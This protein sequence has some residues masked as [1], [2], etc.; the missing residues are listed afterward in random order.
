MTIEK[1]FPPLDIVVRVGDLHVGRFSNSM[2]HFQTTIELYRRLLIPL[3][4]ELF[5]NNPGRNITVLFYG[6]QYDNKQQIS[7]VINDMFIDLNVELSKYAY[8]YYL[9]GN[10]DT[11]MV[12]NVS[13]NANKSFSLVEK[14]DVINTPT[15]IKDI[16]GN[17][18]MLSP[19]IHELKNME[20]LIKISKE[21]NVKELHGHNS[22]Y[23]FQQEGIA[24]EKKNNLGISD[25][26]HFDEVIMGHIHT[27]QKI[28][29]VRYLG[30][31][32][33][34]RWQEAG[35][36]NVIE[37]KDYSSGE[38]RVV[39][40]TFSPK[41]QKFNYL[42]IIEKTVP[43]INELLENNYNEF[44]IPATSKQFNTAF[45]TEHFQ[46][47]KLL[48]FTPMGEVITESFDTNSI[49]I[50]SIEEY[51]GKFIDDLS[52]IML[53]KNPYVI[54]D[55]NRDF[56]KNRFVNDYKEQLQQTKENIN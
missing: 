35:N 55:E 14:M 8:C 41:Y 36:K 49:E 21:A 56:F 23:G 43:E 12:S 26:G 28:K 5:D 53:E 31:P 25:F 38:L 27:M 6:D 34:T 20:K 16:N 17:S 45:F 50:L 19:W 40:N 32:Y 51:Y 1:N 22:I 39:E 44:F 11:P 3:V 33:Q 47:A 42:D 46:K 4:K 13:I 9:V 7:I 18:I 30:T 48:K 10:H 15:I 24:I 54:T 2:S 37:V 52:T 29:N